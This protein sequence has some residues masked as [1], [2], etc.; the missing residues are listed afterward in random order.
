MPNYGPTPAVATPQP[1]YA[2]YKHG[3]HTVDFTPDAGTDYGGGVGVGVP[4]GAVVVLGAMVGIANVPLPA[5]V[6]GALV[7]VGC[8]EFPKAASDGGMAVGTLA[9]W[10]ASAHVATGTG[11]GN[12]Y[13][14]KVEIAA[15]TADLLVRVQVEAVA[16]ASGT[17][18]FGG[19][20]RA[21][22]AA[23]GSTVSDAAAL[24][25]GFNSVTAGDA[26]K[27]VVL[28]T[29]PAAGTV[30]RVKNAAA[31]VLKVYPDTSATINAIGSHGPISM[32]AQTTAD[33][34]A[35]STTQWYTSPLLPS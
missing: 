7:I 24:S 10:D 18:G 2:V 1:L 20:P 4:C 13:L 21:T 33:F 3:A 23:T 5:S 28:P 31:A 35:D 29:A 8:Y 17:V 14:G 19:M 16:N 34:T 15:L 22:V 32:A 6:K 9:Y 12:T 30:V 11:S 27:G 26:T 25:G